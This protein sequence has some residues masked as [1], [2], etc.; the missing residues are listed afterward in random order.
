M[1]RNIVTAKKRKTFMETAL[2]MQKVYG[3]KGKSAYFAGE[4]AGGK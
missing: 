4:L 3:D 1:K 2:R